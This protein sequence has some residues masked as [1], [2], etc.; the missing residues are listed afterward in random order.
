MGFL[1]KVKVQAATAAQKAQEGVKAGQAK[2]VD[3]RAQKTTDALLRDLGAA[4]YAQ[5]TGQAMPETEVEIERLIS[6][7][8]AQEAEHG[9]VQPSAPSAEPSGAAS[10]VGEGNFKLDDL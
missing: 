2:V 3:V 7:L 4:T 8:Q 9:A 10:A 1:D 5:R 6:E